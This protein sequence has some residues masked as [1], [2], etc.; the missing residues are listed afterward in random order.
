MRRYQVILINLLIIIFLGACASQKRAKIKKG[1]KTVIDHRAFENHFQGVF[2]YDPATRDTLFKKNSSKYFTPASNTKIYTLFAALNLLP[3]K[4]PVLKYVFKNDTLYFRG[5]ADG[6]QLHPFFKDSTS[7][8]FLK[9]YDNLSYSPYAIEDEKFGPGWS[10][11]D[12]HWYYSA[13]R[14]ALPLYGNVVFVTNTPELSVSP[15]LFADSIVN[16][17][18]SKNRNPNKN[19]F[20]FDPE[21]KDSTEIPFLTNKILT[22]RMLEDVV[23]KAVNLV[24]Q[25]PEGQQQVLYGMPADS[26]Y[27][28]MMQVSDNFLAE[29]LL[30]QASTAISDTLSSRKTRQ[31]VQ[32][33][34]LSDLQQPPRWVDGSGLSRYNLFSPESLVHVLDKLYSDIPRDRLFSFFPAGGVSGTLE[35]WYPGGDAP[36]IYAKTGSLGNNHSVSGY[37]ITASGK[38]LIFSF[39]NNHFRKPSSE[40][41]ERMQ[42]VFEWVRDNY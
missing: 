27:Q 28:R 10:W 2:I 13:E 5:T 20:F 35:D 6:T 9:K 19:I 23:N 38:T 36:Y 25:M 21:R 15:S 1:I 24:E 18:N 32:D 42:L 3:E 17:S 39:M 34:L 37:L 14:T 7:I 29:Q 41:K 22:K 40:I 8:N 4:L 11:D 26:V 31:Y 16:V 33:S 30:I 12:Y